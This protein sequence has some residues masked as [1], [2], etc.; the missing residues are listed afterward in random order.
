MMYATAA[1]A[2]IRKTI[3]DC[4]SNEVFHIT[5]QISDT[6]LCECRIAG[7]EEEKALQFCYKGPATKFILNNGGKD[8][9]DEF[10]KEY[11]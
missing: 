4:M 8:M 5:E 2:V 11:Y 7:I 1:N 9:I 10:Y 6:D 3:M